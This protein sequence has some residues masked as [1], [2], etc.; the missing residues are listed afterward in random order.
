M[1][2]KA[3]SEEETHIISWIIKCQDINQMKSQE[4]IKSTITHRAII[5]GSRDNHFFVV[6]KDFVIYEVPEVLLIKTRKKLE[7]EG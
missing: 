2:K 3:L 1:I 6:Y 5:F 7:A 4:N